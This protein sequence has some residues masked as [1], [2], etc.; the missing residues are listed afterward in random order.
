MLYDNL[1]KFK[2]RG[3]P[4]K[5]KRKEP[6]NPSILVPN[7]YFERIRR[8]R[9]LDL[10]MDRF[11]LT[12]K[13]YEDFIIEAYSSNV[14]WST[15]LE[16]NPLLE[17]EVKR[18][19]IRT[20]QGD[21][22]ETPGGPR[23]EILNHLV[24][25]A[26]PDQ[27]KLPWDHELILTLHGYLLENTGISFNPG[28]YRDV[29]VTVQDDGGNN[30]LIP[31]PTDKIEEE[32]Q[33]LLDWINK[34]AL[35]YESITAATV[36]F[37]EFESIHPFQDGNGRIGRCLFHLFLQNT[38]LKNSHLCKIES[39][40]LKD[41]EL[42]YQLL[43]YTDETGSYTELIDLVSRAM[44]NS[45]EE[46][47]ATLSGKD[48]LSSNLDESSKTLL[49]K[50]KRIGEWFSV[51]DATNWVDGIGEQSIRKR[52]NDFVKIGAFNKT[53]KTRSCRY[54]FNDPFKKIRQEM[55]IKF[56]LD[57]SIIEGGKGSTI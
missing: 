15:K 22:E 19:T 14:H 12:G 39:H 9:E 18:L 57:K 24:Q 54:I 55:I 2:P 30:L 6:F 21:I 51:E 44:V 41:E 3:Y 56:N 4:V 53:G 52:L 1:R 35:A 26:F 20:F 46:A 43:A 8:I 48:L 31:A 33:F 37:H 32:M 23:Q 45:Y 10:E 11:I 5:H 28:I 40:L 7:G 27:F 38:D 49:K 50:A 42:Y 47:N 29:D 36:L 25:M 16:G 34:K 17:E 13:D